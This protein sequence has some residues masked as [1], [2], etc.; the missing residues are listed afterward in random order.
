MAMGRC[1]V[2]HFAQDEPDETFTAGDYVETG[3]WIVI[4]DGTGPI[5]RIRSGSV[6]RIDRVE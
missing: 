1:K 3:N 2:T 6:K 4:R 5:S